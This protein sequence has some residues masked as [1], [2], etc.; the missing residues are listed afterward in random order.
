MQSLYE[1][2]LKMPKVIQVIQLFKFVKYCIVQCIVLKK[3]YQKKKLQENNNYQENTT[4]I[5]HVLFVSQPYTSPKLSRQVTEMVS[6]VMKTNYI[7]LILVFTD[8]K[9]VFIFYSLK[10]IFKTSL[11]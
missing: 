9:F 7:I 2:T 10:V 5:F 6:P 8:F 11:L 3:I 1:G 4:S